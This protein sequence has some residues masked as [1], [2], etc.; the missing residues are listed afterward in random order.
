[1]N[2]QNQKKQ[3]LI[4][5]NYPSVKTNSNKEKSIQIG[6]KNIPQAPTGPKLKV[7]ME[8]ISHNKNYFKK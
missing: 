2:T 6:L 8:G 5:N 4:Q 7:A 1:M 3:I